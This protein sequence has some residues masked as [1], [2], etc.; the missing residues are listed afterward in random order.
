MQTHGSEIWRR[1]CM[2]YVS[3]TYNILRD[4]NHRTIGPETIDRSMIGNERHFCERTKTVYWSRLSSNGVKNPALNPTSK[5]S[6]IYRLHPELEGKKLIYQLGTGTPELAVKAA[7][8]VA[9]DVAGIDVNS[10]CPKPFS[11]TGGMGAAL[12]KDPDR[13]CSIL[14]ALVK[15]VG[16]KFEIGISVKIRILAKKEDTEILVRR[17]VKT[18]ITGLTVHC[19]TTPMRPRERAIR[20]QLMMIA[21]ICREAGVACLMNGDV[22]SRDEALALMKEFNVD[23]A[24]IATAAEKSPSVFRSAVDG[25]S[26]P[27]KEM[28][29]SYLEA[30]MSV[31]NRWGNT[32]FTLAQL[33]P[34]KEDKFIGISQCKSHEDVVNALGFDDLLD[35]ARELDT[36]L[37][38]KNPDLTRVAKR[39]AAR[40]YVKEEGK[41]VKVEQVDEEKEAMHASD[42]LATAAI[43][44]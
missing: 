37:Q 40:E 16:Q 25:G 26:A 22:M 32:K 35:L 7:T 31:D 3:S 12:L 43:A 27:W 17:L 15:E 30:A 21:D 10:G 13:L 24:M 41:R 8:L 14:E 19:R 28:V 11:T 33:I 1:S 29:R 44:A 9:A 39:A 18:G 2:G 20:D 38:L 5:E 6:V 42:G 36:R 34:G 23:G 4:T